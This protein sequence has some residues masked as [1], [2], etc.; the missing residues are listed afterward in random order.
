MEIKIDIYI[1]PEYLEIYRV[2]KEVVGS[3]S[4]WDILSNLAYLDCLVDGW[5]GMLDSYLFTTYQVNYVKE[6]PEEAASLYSNE[7]YSIQQ[8]DG[9]THMVLPA[10]D[11]EQRDLAMM[12]FDNV[13]SIYY[14]LTYMRKDFE[15]SVRLLSD[16]I[17]MDAKINK[18]TDIHFDTH[19]NED[20][21]FSYMVNFRQGIYLVPQP[22]YQIN[23]ALVDDIIEDMLV[24]R[25]AV[26]HKLAALSVSSSARFRL[27]DPL[28]PSRCQVGKSI[29]GK[30]LTIRQFNFDDAPS[31]ERLGFNEATQ[32][33][34]HKSSVTPNGLTLVSGVFGSGK[35]TTLNAVG[36]EME[37]TGRLS[38]ASL[39]DPIEYLRKYKQY[40]YS[41]ENQLEEFVDAFK[42]MD[43]N[44]VYL[45]EIITNPVAE[46]VFNLVSSGV[47]VLTTIHTNRVYRI[48]Y[49]LEELLGSK[50]LSMVP[51]LNVISYQDKFSICCDKCSNGISIQAYR[52]DS[53]EHKLLSFLGLETIRQSFGCSECNHGVKR[54]GIKV[55]S[56]HIEFNDEVKRSLLRM[57]LH[58]QYDYL[59]ELTSQGENLESVIREALLKGEVMI[60]EAL[61]KLDT[62]R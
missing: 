10:S 27:I 50:Y 30:T 45:N 43:L 41:N 17:M 44:I 53:D 36:K 46:A 38:I 8:A 13:S 6:I 61:L 51:F 5:E 29:G 18:A 62:W 22:K 54:N 57:D 4:K 37:K 31:I 28:F 58:Q 2:F 32:K 20:G 55:V 16:V 21:S 11:R 49:K 47:H 42:K 24:N 34:L 48:M 9:S 56:E 23:S 52:E 1:K 59:K 26:G 33:M 14:T 25:S 15:P 19:S 40:E 12:F 35:G 60:K 39:D 7:E 3:M